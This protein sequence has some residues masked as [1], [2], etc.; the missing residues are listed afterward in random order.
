MTEAEVIKRARDGCDEAWSMLLDQHAG[1]INKAI[2]D[3]VRRGRDRDD[4]TSVAHEVMLRCVR[5]WNSDKGVKF[6]TYLWRAMANV[7]HT[8]GYGGAIRVPHNGFA[9]DPSKATKALAAADI[10]DESR[11]FTSNDPDV[12]D[13][14]DRAR[15]MELVAAL[16]KRDK[17]VMVGRMSNRTLQDIAGDLRVSKERVRQ[18]ESQ[19]VLLLNC[20]TTRDARSLARARTSLPSRHLQILEQ[21]IRSR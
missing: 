20:I 10:E 1:V 6:I 5:R 15:V 4:A 19:A 9:T 21:H 3:S 16:P 11:T 2:N 7:K 18:L 17:Q 8:A 13:E 12:V 14:L